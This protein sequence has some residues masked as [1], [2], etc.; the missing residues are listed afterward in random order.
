MTLIR[1]IA[2]P[3]LA[4]GFVL[5]GVNALK[6]SEKLAPTAEP[7][8]EKLV[9]MAQKAVPQVSLPS[10]PQTWVRINAVTQI[11]AAAAL[12]TGKAPRVSSAV[13]AASVVPTTLAGHAFW[14]Q[15]TDEAKKAQRIQFA[16][17]LSILGGLLLASVDTDGKPGVAWRAQRAAKDVR[18]EA[19]RAAHEAALQSRLVVEKAR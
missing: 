16:K 1:L 11:V 14:D 19:K 8:T 7:V 13:L 12:A 18:R 10:D 15:D 17:N 9:P 3:L 6:N 5:G 2:R 4:S